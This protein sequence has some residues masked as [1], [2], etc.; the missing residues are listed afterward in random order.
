M[1]GDVIPD[2]PTMLRNGPGSIP[3]H[4]WELMRKCWDYEPQRRPTAEELQ[5]F[6]EELS[7]KDDRPPI[8]DD[9]VLQNSTTAESESDRVGT[10]EILWKVGILQEI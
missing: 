7:V 2:C 10:L 9:L 8:E 5:K 4:I 3:G 6:F 1:K